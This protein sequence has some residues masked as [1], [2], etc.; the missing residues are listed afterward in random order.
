M[1]QVTLIEECAASLPREG[2]YLPGLILCQQF[3][4][5]VASLLILRGEQDLQVPLPLNELIFL[6]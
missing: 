6:S 2:R 3:E 5:P 1:F 4:Q